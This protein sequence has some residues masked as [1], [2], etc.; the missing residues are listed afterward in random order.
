M[1]TSIQRLTVVIGY[2]SKMDERVNPRS[3]SI[4]VLGI[5]I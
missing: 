1:T 4:P 3:S 5:P 2:P